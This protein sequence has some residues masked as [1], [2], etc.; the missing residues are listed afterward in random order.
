MNISIKGRIFKENGSWCVITPLIEYP[1]F[2]NK[3]LLC[4]QELEK[5]LKI[6]MNDESVSCFFRVDDEGVFY[7]VTMH[8]PELIEYIVSKV[9]DL[10]EIRIEPNLDQA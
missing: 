7:L 3:P 6:E 10:N 8:T 5:A 4:L 1:I 2:C 9:F